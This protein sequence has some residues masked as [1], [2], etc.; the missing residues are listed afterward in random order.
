MHI[1]RCI[2]AVTPVIAQDYNS[3]YARVC[4]Y[5]E[6]SCQVCCPIHNVLLTFDT[7]N[8]TRVPVLCPFALP[9]ESTSRT[10]TLQW[11]LSLG[12]L[13]NMQ[14]A[15]KITRSQVSTKP[16]DLQPGNTQHVPHWIHPP[17][18]RYNKHITWWHLP[19][20]KIRWDLSWTSTPPREAHWRTLFD[21]PSL[22]LHLLSDCRFLF[23]ISLDHGRSFSFIVLTRCLPL[24]IF[25][26]YELLPDSQIQTTN[27]IPKLNLINSIRC[28]WWWWRLLLLWSTVV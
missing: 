2:H 14:V 22:R 21:R 11:V 26:W 28:P 10:S 15:G 8:T 17:V 27:V 7:L 20:F 16:Q 6:F 5:T 13:A 1:H 9:L 19:L 25:S 12:Q 18:T 24:L 4:I 3:V 23:R